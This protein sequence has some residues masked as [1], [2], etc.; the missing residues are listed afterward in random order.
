MLPRRPRRPPGLSEAGE[1]ASAAH[2]P[3]SRTTHGRRGRRGLADAPAAPARARSGRGAGYR[4][5]WAAPSDR[6]GQQV[7]VRDESR[8][9]S[10]RARSPGRCVPQPGSA[11]GRGGHRKHA[12]GTAVEALARMHVGGRDPPL[13]QL[14]RRRRAPWWS[15]SRRRVWFPNL[16]AQEGAHPRPKVRIDDPKMFGTSAPAKPA[17]K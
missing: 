12:A 5:Q 4:T 8:R 7:R 16:V 11:R 6:R 9:P 1:L 17:P 13:E 15:A 14:R 2:A 3:P 10:S